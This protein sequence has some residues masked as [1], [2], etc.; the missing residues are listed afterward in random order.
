MANQDK[1]DL[2]DKLR[3]AEVMLSQITQVMKGKPVQ[4]QF[5]TM[6]A[7]TAITIAAM[8]KELRGQILETHIKNVNMIIEDID[9]RTAKN[10]ITGNERNS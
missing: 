2:E 7:I 5:Y 8:P 3:I 9:A 1:P 10:I 4:A 6:D